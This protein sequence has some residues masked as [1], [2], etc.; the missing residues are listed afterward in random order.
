MDYSKGWKGGHPH[1]LVTARTDQ[2]ATHSF[3]KL[4]AAHVADHQSLYNRLAIDL[5]TTDASQRALPIN[6]RL[7]AVREGTL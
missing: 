3:P 4:L 6:Q 2:A 7:A 5:G 1:T